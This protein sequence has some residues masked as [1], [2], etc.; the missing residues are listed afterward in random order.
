M[1]RGPL[2][3]GFACRGFYALMIIVPIS[4]IILFSFVIFILPV[5]QIKVIILTALAYKL[6]IQTFGKS[7]YP[8][9][10]LLLVHNE[11]ECGQSSSVSWLF[12]VTTPAEMQLLHGSE[13]APNLQG[14]MNIVAT[15]FLTLIGEYT[16][17]PL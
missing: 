9:S 17:P 6:V 7:P 14:R 16:Q 13:N 10:V 1:T 12:L 5:T 2:T 4:L 15:L 11:K 3:I 8:R